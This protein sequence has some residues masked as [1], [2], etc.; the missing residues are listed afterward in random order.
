MV[1]VNIGVLR[2]NK[3]GQRFDFILLMNIKA[4]IWFY[5]WNVKNGTKVRIPVLILNR[6]VNTGIEKMSVQSA[7]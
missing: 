5:K 4:T 7:V 6:I 3:P 1:Q 2:V